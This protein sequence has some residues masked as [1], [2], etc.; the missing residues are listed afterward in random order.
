[1]GRGI[2]GKSKGDAAM[3]KMIKH[4]ERSARDAER[5]GPEKRE[6]NPIIRQLK[7][8]YPTTWELEYEE[9]K[10]EARH[11]EYLNEKRAA[12]EKAKADY[13]NMPRR[14]RENETEYE[15]CRKAVNKWKAE[16]R[17]RFK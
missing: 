3:D 4:M 6:P 8:L 7:E 11:P 13:Y 9:M 14:E 17:E 12:R 10:L 16:N 2:I 15:Y 1:M 5:R